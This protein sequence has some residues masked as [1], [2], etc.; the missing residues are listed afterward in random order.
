MATRYLPNNNPNWYYK[1]KPAFA[2]FDQTG[3]I[4]HLW[5]DNDAEPS[6]WF[7]GKKFSYIFAIQTPD[8]PAGEYTW[9]I[10]IIDKTKE[11]TPG[12]HLAVRDKPLLNGWIMVNKVS[13]HTY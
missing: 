5:V 3:K 1:Y 13:I 6:G 10:A 12:I 11:N 4:V 2:L 9:A 7:A 8:I